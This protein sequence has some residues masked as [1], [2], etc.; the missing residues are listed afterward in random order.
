MLFYEVQCNQ[1]SEFQHECMWHVMT[2]WWKNGHQI[3][4]RHFWDCKK[5][6]HFFFHFC[7][8]IKWQM[9]ISIK[10]FNIKQLQVCGMYKAWFT[11]WI[12]FLHYMYFLCIF[13][14]QIR[15]TM[16]TCPLFFKTNLSVLSISRIPLLKIETAM[17]QLCNDFKPACCL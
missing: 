16:Y 1:T 8:M 17:Q 3:I 2:K 4:Q 7:K 15:S 12:S 13:S 14:C 10:M 11:Q 6:C 9:S 5:I